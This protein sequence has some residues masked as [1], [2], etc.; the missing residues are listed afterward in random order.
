[1]S[2]RARVA[3]DEVLDGSPSRLAADGGRCCCFRSYRS[4]TLCRASLRL[5]RVRPPDAA[6]VDVGERLDDL[7][8]G[9]SR[10]RNASQRQFSRKWNH[11]VNVDH[12]VEL[13]KTC[14]VRNVWNDLESW[15]SHAWNAPLVGLFRKWNLAER[16]RAWI[17][18]DGRQHG[19]LRR[20]GAWSRLE[21]VEGVR[22]TEHRGK[23]LVVFVVVDG[24]CGG[25]GRTGGLL[26]GGDVHLD[27]SSPLRMALGCALAFVHF[28]ASFVDSAD[29]ISR[30][31]CL[32]C[33]I[34]PRVMSF[35]LLLLRC[36]NKKK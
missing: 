10:V 35:I 3:A 21:R 36:Y 5:T 30:P 22:V 23:F 24:G 20:R 31:R 19:V 25:E 2:T 14:N 16:F 29:D 9:S 17:V 4:R 15:K 32:R 7:E 26:F 33:P 11:L 13:G 6:A 18:S 12:S 1:V 34:H 8:R 28:T 27:W